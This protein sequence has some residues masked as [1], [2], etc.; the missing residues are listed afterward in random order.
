MNKKGF[1]L[2]E[3]L[4][5]LVILGVIMMIAIPTMMST[6][7]NNKKKTYV[8]DAKRFATLAELQF[9]KSNEDVKTCTMSITSCMDNDDYGY[10]KSYY[11]KDVNDGT[12]TN[13]PDGG[14]YNIDRSHIDILKVNTNGY[15]EYKYYVYLVGNRTVGNPDGDNNYMALVDDLTVSNVFSK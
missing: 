7:D 14:S 12:I 4:A 2:V 11:L 13:D 8:S 15:S 5:V 3:L 9:K 10:V 1:T 6:L